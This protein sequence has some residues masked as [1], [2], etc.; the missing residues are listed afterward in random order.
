VYLA[1]GGKFGRP[2]GDVRAQWF[3]PEIRNDFALVIVGEQGGFFACL[4]VALLFLFIFYQGLR[5]ALLSKSMMG[6]STALGLTLL[7]VMQAAVNMAVVAA[8]VPP[9]GISLPFLSYGGSNMLV[10]GLA[11]GLL[12]SVARH[13]REPEEVCSQADPLGFHGLEASP[14]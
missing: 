12:V 2:L 1:A 6:F 11:L 5:I 9:K 14:Q 13:A 7:I 4:L 10:N 3:V 8:L